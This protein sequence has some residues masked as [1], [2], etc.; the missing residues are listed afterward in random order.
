MTKPFILIY[1]DANEEVNPIFNT[2]VS[3]EH[4]N[5]CVRL[6]KGFTSFGHFESQL[7]FGEAA[8]VFLCAEAFCCCSFL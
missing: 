6:A 8:G 1:S 7:L 5:Q 2:F 4:L 3:A